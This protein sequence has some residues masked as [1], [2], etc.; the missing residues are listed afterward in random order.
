VSVVFQAT[1]DKKT[2]VPESART[3]LQERYDQIAEFTKDMLD[4]FFDG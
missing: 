2:V 4:T 1:L 3:I